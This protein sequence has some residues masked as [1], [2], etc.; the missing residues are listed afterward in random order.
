MQAPKRS[1]RPLEHAATRRKQYRHPQPVQCSPPT[2][3]PPRIPRQG[4]SQHS[5]EGKHTHRPQQ[6]NHDLY[7]FIYMMSYDPQDPELRKSTILI[8]ILILQPESHPSHLI[9]YPI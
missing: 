4:E 9:I 8:L 5:A 3:S 1:P 6:E 2:A 7:L